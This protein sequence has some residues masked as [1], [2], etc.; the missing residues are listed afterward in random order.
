M[1]IIKIQD[2][3]YELFILLLMVFTVLYVWFQ[4]KFTYWSSKGVFG[5]TPVFPFG[6]IQDVIKRKTQ[7]FQPYCDN[8]FKYKHLPY[9]GMYCFNKPVLSIHDADLAKHI[10]IKDF[11]HFQSHGI[12]SGGVGDP[13]AGH[14]FNL[15]GSAWKLLRNKMTSAFSA[16]KLKCMYPLVEKISKEALAY[17][18]VLHA[19][20][21]SINFSEFYEKYTMEII[22]SVGFGVE[23]N[24]F[25]NSN[26][27]FYLRGHEYFNPNSLYW[28]L[29]RALAFFMPNFFDKLKIRRINPDILNFFDNLVRETVEYRHRHSYKRNDFLQTLIDLNNDSSKCEER[30]SQKGGFTLTDVTS[31]TMLYM[32]AGYETSATTGQ[33]AAY[34][35]AKNPHIQTKARE[36]IRKVLAKYDGECSYEAQGEMTYM[37]MI[38]DETMRM[39]PP[40]R[41]LFRGCTKE[42]RIPDSDVTIEEG[43]LVLIPIHSI[44]MDP[45]IFQDPETFDPERFS[46]ER[47]KLIHPC[48]WMPFGEGPRK[49]LG[50]RQGYI[51][52]KLALVKLLHKYELLLDDRTAVPMKIKAT[53]LACAAD[54]G[55]WIRLKKLTESVN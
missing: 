44:Q 34:E 43:T 4:Y 18:D 31:N 6:N 26:S 13:L 38:L 45:E 25:K 17:G 40:L 24:G 23:C 46:P 27:E 36:E 12:F 48:H 51:Q 15:H 9:I 54:G 21:E 2:Y 49:C 32:F 52:S 37:N 50:L 14:L 39:Y 42:Y 20:G 30:E 53:S 47:K 29:I 5:P 19:R 16:C 41:S 11:E 7:F 33:F 1:A 3:A 35:L 22:G 28:T 8:Y 10:L 55:V